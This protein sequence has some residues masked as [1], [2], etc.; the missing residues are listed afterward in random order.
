MS[1]IALTPDASG[2]GTF[3]IAAPNSNT[4]RTLTLPDATGILFSNADVASQA[5][6]EA[7]TDNTTL[8]TPLRATQALE[9]KTEVLLQTQTVTS[10]VATLVFTS[11]V[12]DNTKFSSYRVEFEGVR[13]S[14][15]ASLR[16]RTSSDG[17]S[18]FAS[19]ASDYRNIAQQWSASSSS[20][21]GGSEAFY[22]A[23]SG[24]IEST[25]A[26]ASGK[27]T[28]FEANVAAI[29]HILSENVFF[30]SSSAYVREVIGGARFASDIIDGL[31][32]S[33]STGNI[34]GGT[35]KLYGVK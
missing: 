15:D 18:T 14:V 2:T 16:M 10:A 29:S 26:G 23:T 9:A 5:A 12:M 25:A 1:K 27:I 35:F 13:G 24:S 8:I 3:T 31:Q 30:T 34:A 7:G 17:G 33:M 20:F 6:A 21:G 32:F 4:N 19:G 11:S 22:R 28:I